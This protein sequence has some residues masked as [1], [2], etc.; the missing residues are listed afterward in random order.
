MRAILHLCVL[1][2]VCAAEL[3]T[4][5][6]RE[7]RQHQRVTVIRPC[8]MDHKSQRGS[9]SAS[10]PPALLL[11][12]RPAPSTTTT[13]AWRRLA[14]HNEDEQYSHML[15]PS[16]AHLPAFCFSN[17]PGPDL[18]DRVSLV[19]AARVEA[20]GLRTR[21][22]E[23]YVITG[24]RTYVSDFVVPLFGSWLTSAGNP[25]R[26]HI[27]PTNWMNILKLAMNAKPHSLVRSPSRNCAGADYVASHIT[28]PSQ[29]WNSL[30][31]V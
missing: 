9:L 11:R 15:P 13:D 6:K 25:S 29:M 14:S 30:R 8:Q 19:P 31:E 28:G 4:P 3:P 16:Q 20:L 12:P 22:C 27:I 5:R 1:R 2:A 10:R 18:C 21:V 26:Y 24:L 17:K 7:T 23:D